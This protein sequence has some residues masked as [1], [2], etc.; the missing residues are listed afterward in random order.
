MQ[1]QFG[2]L[3]GYEEGQMAKAM[4]QERQQTFINQSI[5]QWPCTT[6]KL[7]TLNCATASK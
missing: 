7:E 2:L 5:N 4:P 6:D 1:Q 3:G